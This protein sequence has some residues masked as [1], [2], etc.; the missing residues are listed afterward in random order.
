MKNFALLLTVLLYMTLVMALAEWAVMAQDQSYTLKSSA[1]GG[2]SAAP[3]EA[4]HYSLIGT[5]DPN[6]QQTL[7][8]GAY[9]V[10]SAHPTL[11]N[12]LPTPESPGERTKTLFIP[13]VE[14]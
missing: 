12:R 10:Q 13:L 2:I 3:S 5:S 8:G 9:S 4:G 11:L 1:F 7:S 6:A 14:P